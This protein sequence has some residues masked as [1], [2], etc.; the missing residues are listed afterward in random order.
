MQESSFFEVE[1]NFKRKKTFKVMGRDPNGG[2][3]KASAT[4]SMIN[5]ADQT[6]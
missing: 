3:V 5:C 1:S 4:K 2:A 6:P